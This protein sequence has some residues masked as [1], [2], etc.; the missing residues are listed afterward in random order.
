MSNS[1]DLLNGGLELLVNGM[2]TV[3]VFLVVLIFS[4]KAM[5]AIVAKFPD[6]EAAAPK[7][8]AVNVQN[9]DLQEIAAV[10]A[11]VQAYK[12]RT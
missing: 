10:A 12:S 4:T 11:A 5:S 8:P 7:K 3:F 1:T 2:G 9:S 6:N